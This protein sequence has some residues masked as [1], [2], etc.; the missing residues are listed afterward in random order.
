V[1]FLH[2]NSISDRSFMIWIWYVGWYSILATFFWQYIKIP[3][4]TST[5]GKSLVTKAYSSAKISDIQ[6][7]DEKILLKKYFLKGCLNRKRNSIR[8]AS[9]LVQIGFCHGFSMLYTY[10][11]CKNFDTLSKSIL[12]YR[13]KRNKQANYE[14][15]SAGNQ[16]KTE[17]NL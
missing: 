12:I 3:Q 9:T 10:V 5:R 6:F 4:K 15:I 8:S 2:P 11:L 13:S 1:R 14:K 17:K 7:C 16:L